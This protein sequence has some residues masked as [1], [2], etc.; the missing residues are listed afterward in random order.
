MCIVNILTIII[1][2]ARDCS[3]ALVHDGGRATF[4]DCSFKGSPLSYGVVARDARTR[5]RKC[6]AYL[7]GRLGHFLTV[8]KVLLENCLVS[9][10]CCSNVLASDGATLN[11]MQG[12]RC[13][14]VWMEF[15]D[16]CHNS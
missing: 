10:N 2:P 5:V 1:R 15:H 13:E 9:S 6:E 16:D 11:L 4:D 12:C 14:Y 8:L 7:R 3:V